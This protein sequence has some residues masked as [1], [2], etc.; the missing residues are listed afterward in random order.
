[1]ARKK[2]TGRETAIVSKMLNSIKGI[3]KRHSLVV[4]F[5]KGKKSPFNSPY[6]LRFHYYI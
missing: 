3:E 6:F 4:F 1:M 2:H 5:P